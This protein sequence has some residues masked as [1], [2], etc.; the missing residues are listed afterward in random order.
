METFKNSA[1]YLVCSGGSVGYMVATAVS[2]GMDGIQRS[3]LEM[4]RQDSPSP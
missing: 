1:L 4:F 3:L 2:I